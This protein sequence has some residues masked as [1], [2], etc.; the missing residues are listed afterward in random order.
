MTRDEWQAIDE[1]RQ[2]LNL[3]ER[4]TMGEIKRAYRQMCKRYHPDV[5]GEGS[6]ADAAIIRELTRGYDLIMR[7][8]ELFRIPL[9]PA[10]GD[11]IEPED[12]WMDRFGNDP[13]WGSKKGK[14]KA[15]SKK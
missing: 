12:W 2:L 14:A 6:P 10:D 3:A 7:Y 9:V 15:A 11:N 8:C 4:A 13:L 5:V 1:A